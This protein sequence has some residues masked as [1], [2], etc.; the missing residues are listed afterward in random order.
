MQDSV[1]QFK[2]ILW[3]IFILILNGVELTIDIMIISRL[4]TFI[5]VE[6]IIR[7]FD[8]EDPLSFTF[9]L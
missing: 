3:T 9:L 1:E 8:Y 2:K 6:N 4:V 7:A 5:I